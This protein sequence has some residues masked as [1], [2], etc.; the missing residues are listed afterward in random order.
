MTTTLTSDTDI[1]AR[2]VRAELADLA[3]DEIDDLTD[4]LEADLAERLADAPG[5]TLGDPVAYAAELRAAAGHPPR[6]SRSH[7]GAAA[8]LPDL[9]GLLVALRARWASLRE[10]HP[11]VGGAVAMLVA[12]RPVWWVFRGVI[13]AMLVLPFFVGG[14]YGAPMNGGVWLTILAAV[15]LSVQAGRGAWLRRLWLKRSVV[16]VSVVV[17]IVAPWVIASALG[18][19]NN[20][21]NTYYFSSTEVFPDGLS[22]NGQSVG[23]IYAYD[24]DG[25]PIDQVQ[26]F[27]QFGDPLD[28]AGDP[29]A[30]WAVGPHDAPVVP[31]SEVPGRAGWNVYPLA[32]FTGDPYGADP[33]YTD[34]RAAEF[35]LDSVAPLSG[36]EAT[37]AAPE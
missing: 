26:L 34:R 33:D 7:L 15:V 4:G 32:E 18:G 6:S 19:L 25:N 21:Y 11:F 9:R 1:F 14:D 28:L 29:M 35:P 27:D 23:N 31:S 20:M 36:H 12:V 16:A 17:V 24:A 5:E 10:R 37:S 30:P 22:Y 8:A 3:P 13:V 2:A